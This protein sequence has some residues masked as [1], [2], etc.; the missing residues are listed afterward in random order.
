MANDTRFYADIFEPNSE[1]TGSFNFVE[2]KINNDTVKFTVDCG[3]Y[4]EKGYEEQNLKFPVDPKELDFVIL[5]HNH[6][7]HSGR[8]PYLVN[9]GFDKPI[10]TT[11]ATSHLVSKALYDNLKV[12]SDTSR[13]NNN[14]ALYTESDVE[15]TL[16][17]IVPCE[18]LEPVTVNDH[19][20]LHF[21]W[22]GHLVGAAS[23]LVQIKNGGN[24]IWILF[25]GD[26][27]TKNMFFHVP[28][29]RNWIKELPNLTVVCESTY[30]TME[31]KEIE[32]CFEDNIIRALQDNKTIIIP[33]F[34]LGRSQ[35]VL[36][37]IKEMQKSGIT[38]LENIPI[39]F[40]GK[41][42]FAYTELYWKLWEEEQERIEEGNNR[43]IVNFYEE[44]ID[45]LPKNLRYVTDKLVRRNVIADNKSKIVVT[46]S[47]MGSYGP[48]Q[49]YIPAFIQRKDALIHFTG[50]CAEGTLGRRLKDAEIGDIVRIGGLDVEKKGNV[51]FTNE[52]T[53]HA[54]ADELAQYLMQFNSL[55]TVLI[56]HG[57]TEAKE[58]F[59]KKVI[60]TVKP[61][62]VGRL[63]EGYVFRID[64]N[65]FDKQ[66]SSKFE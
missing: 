17:N 66:M 9:Q 35:E 27:N 43:R 22:N 32:H 24:S 48:A 39:Y 52:F 23:V 58:T 53:A 30:G 33:A 4:Q 25:T 54:K 46:T 50:Y 15:K 16:Q 37:T 51:E 65:G 41:L 42:A 31:S 40:D 55:N 62:H 10:Y 64:S 60:R 26:L 47:G 18:Y 28:P 7:D 38:E 19:V 1:V 36:C 61:K 6:I 29:Y 44:K 34:S 63:G 21:L 56:N 8:L 57:S 20:A 13:R 14:G 45:F 2:L 49:T 11:V 12:M 3:M 59:A 5:T